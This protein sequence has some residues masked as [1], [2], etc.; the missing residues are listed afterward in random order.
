MAALTA[1]DNIC[2]NVQSAARNSDKQLNHLRNRLSTTQ[3]AVSKV[4]KRRNSGGVVCNL[5][6]IGVVGA[7]AIGGVVACKSAL[8][9][10]NGTL[11][12]VN[13][14][15]TGFAALYRRVCT[16]KSTSEIR[17]ALE[18][19]STAVVPSEQEEREEQAY[20]DELAGESY[21]NPLRFGP[22]PNASGLPGAEA[23][24]RAGTAQPDPHIQPDT[25][26]SSDSHPAP[27]FT[28]GTFGRAAASAVP[29]RR[30][31]PSRIVAEFTVKGRKYAL[32]G[33]WARLAFTAKE[34]FRGVAYTSYNHQ[35]LV[36]WLDQKLA[37]E[38]NVRFTD[39]RAY[40]GLVELFVWYVDDQEKALQEAY[41]ELKADG[42][43][44]MSAD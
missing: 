35:S 25:G 38:E 19:L 37:E 30:R 34:R 20:A 9:I 32:T 43:I 22:V 1:F 24:D 10:A 40:L 16:S 39:R 36:R 2:N 26:G 7:V 41:S 33:F 17:A 18:S 3:R 29:L 6:R 31:K 21:G 5:G 15:K 8:W 28:F 11:D 14:I 13:S 44:R 12:N 27:A 23:A 42:R 4:G